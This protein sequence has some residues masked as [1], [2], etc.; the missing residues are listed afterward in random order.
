MVK[1]EIAHIQLCYAL[2]EQALVIDLDIE[3][4]CTLEQAI[5]ISGLLT[6][7]PE[8]DLTQNKIGI[9]GKLKLLDTVALWKKQSRIFRPQEHQMKLVDY[10]VLAILKIF[11]PI[12]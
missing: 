7:F 10:F 3:A 5:S 11:R 8:I 6:Q 9:Y 4:G 1:R 2:P 12:L